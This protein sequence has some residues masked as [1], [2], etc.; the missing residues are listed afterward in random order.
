MEER[1]CEQLEKVAADS[2]T[3]AAFLG[4]RDVLALT[5]EA[6]LARLGR[7]QADVMALFGGSILAGGDVLAAAMRARVAGTYGPQ[8]NIRFFLNLS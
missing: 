4:L 7:R 2:N 8:R 6:M 3:L 5:Q 1:S